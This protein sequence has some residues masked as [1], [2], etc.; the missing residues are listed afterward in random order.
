VLLGW[1]LKALVLR[2][3]GFTVFQRCKPFAYGITLGGTMTLTL[4]IL[5]R[6]FFPTAES[7]IID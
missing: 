3:G 6:L 4:W 7:I 1:A 5:L 2:Y